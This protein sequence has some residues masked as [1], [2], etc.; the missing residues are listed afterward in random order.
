MHD[1]IF[2]FNLP[3]LRIDQFLP[4]ICDPFFTEQP[5]G[6]LVKADF[7]IKQSD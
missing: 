4:G 1:T 5:A 6:Y 7:A 3:Y 2:A